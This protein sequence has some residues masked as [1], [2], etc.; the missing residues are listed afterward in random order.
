MGNAEEKDE[1]EQ[2]ALQIAMRLMKEANEERKKKKKEKKRRKK[3]RKK[4]VD[5]NEGGL[6][7]L[8]GGLPNLSATSTEDVRRK[9]RKRKSGLPKRAPGDSASMDRASS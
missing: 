2:R 5:G 9:Q 6:P 8:S 3:R 7:S 4:T 1:A